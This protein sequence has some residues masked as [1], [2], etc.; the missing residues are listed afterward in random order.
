M[1]SAFKLPLAARALNVPKTQ[2]IAKFTYF[3]R[4]FLRMYSPEPF[5]VRQVQKN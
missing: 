2:D 3:K 1:S 5:L 4:F